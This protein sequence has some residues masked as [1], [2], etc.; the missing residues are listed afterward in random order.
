MPAP[1]V[2]SKA[3]ASFKEKFPTD[4]GMQDKARKGAR[5]VRPAL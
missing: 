2:P 4:T 1:S 3:G 5:G